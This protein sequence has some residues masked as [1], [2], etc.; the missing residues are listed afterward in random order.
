M[1]L[2]HTKNTKII[3]QKWVI[4]I[5]DPKIFK[6]HRVRKMVRMIEVEFDIRE[7]AVEA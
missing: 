4:F 5:F 3:H 6:V 7:Y 2:L 1:E